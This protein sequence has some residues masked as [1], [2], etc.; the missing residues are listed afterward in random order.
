M[1]TL[2]IVVAQRNPAIAD[3]LARLLQLR[4]RHVAVAHSRA[5]LSGEIWR[6]R[7]DAAVV[8]LELFNREELRQLCTDF[9]GTA[10]IVTHHAPDEAMWK[11]CMDAGALD[12]CHCD[13]EGILRAI[14][15][16]LQN[17]RHAYARAA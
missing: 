8:D 4:V 10:L 13:A 7:P 17:T 1:H 6:M 12:C 14:S 16:Y 3:E 9:R 15:H 11:A 2:S 5:E